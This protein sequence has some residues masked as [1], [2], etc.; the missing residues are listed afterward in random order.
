LREDGTVHGLAGRFHAFVWAGQWRRHPPSAL[1]SGLD[2]LPQRF[3]AAE[4]ESL[5]ISRC[6]GFSVAK[7]VLRSRHIHKG[8]ALPSV[9]EEKRR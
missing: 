3:N 2:A 1:Q 9:R 4:V 6:G 7:I 5:R 8:D